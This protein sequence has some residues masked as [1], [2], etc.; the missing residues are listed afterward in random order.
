MSEPR[1]FNSDAVPEGPAFTVNSYT[2]GQQSLPS[3]AVDATGNFLVVWANR[4]DDGTWELQARQFDANATPLGGEIRVNTDIYVSFP[5][6]DVAASGPGD[7][8]VVWSGYRQGENSA[9]VFGRRYGDRVF[10]DGFN[11]NVGGP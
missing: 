11:W 5:V 3:V 10:T 4:P 1:L 2:T 9:D 7:F 8:V 6:A